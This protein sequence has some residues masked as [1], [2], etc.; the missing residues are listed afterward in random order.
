[1]KFLAVF[2]CV[3]AVSHAQY[4]ASGWKPQGAQLVLPT[5]YGAPGVEAQPQDLEIEITKENLEYAGQ[6]GEE[7]TTAAEPNNA[8][9]PPTTTEIPED[10]P[11]EEQT[12]QPKV[13]KLRQLPLPLARV[14]EQPHEIYGAPP[15]PVETTIEPESEP[16]TEENLVETEAEEVEDGNVDLPSIAIANSGQYYVLGQDNTL[17]KVTF[18]TQRDSQTNGFSAQLRYAPVEPIRD[19]IYAYNAQGQ[20]VKVY[21]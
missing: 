15:A 6:L 2:A 4:V 10:A 1:M 8:Y 5:E 13:G 20:L 11:E 7:T 12:E 14:Q 9:L 16:V 18:N 19:P 17:Q 21:N 3:L